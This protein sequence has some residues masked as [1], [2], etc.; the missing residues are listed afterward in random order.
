MVRL[1]SCHTSCHLGEMLDHDILVFITLLLDDVLVN[2]PH[3]PGAASP[4]AKVGQ[5]IVG[6]SKHNADTREKMPEV[7]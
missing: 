7:V 6:D 5:V 4:A 2:F 1:F 3:H